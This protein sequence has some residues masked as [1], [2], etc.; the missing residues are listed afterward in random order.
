MNEENAK[1]Q[2]KELSKVE[3]RDIE[4]GSVALLDKACPKYQ[5]PRTQIFIDVVE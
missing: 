2:V 3:M 5:P 4:G 1:Y